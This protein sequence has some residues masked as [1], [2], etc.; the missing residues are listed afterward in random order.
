M[1]PFHFPAARGRL[2]R[3]ERGVALLGAG[4]ILLL[5]ILAVDPGVHEFFHKEAGHLGH[6]CVVTDFAAG[7]GVFLAPVIDLRPR[8]IA[9]VTVNLPARGVWRSRGELRLPPACGP[10]AGARS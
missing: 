8:S 6:D 4:L 5:G 3:L 2:S 7:D 10:P 1:N 9:T